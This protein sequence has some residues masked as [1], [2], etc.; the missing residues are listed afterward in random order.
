MPPRTVAHDGPVYQRPFH[1]PAWQDELQADGAEKLP[2]PADRAS[3]ARRCCG[4]SAARTSATGRGSPTSTTATCSATPCSRSRRTPAWCAST[5]RP[6]SGVALATDCN[7]RFAKLDPYAGARLALAESYRNV[8]VSGAQPLAVSDCLNFGS[9]EDPEVMWQFAEAVRGLAD[10]CQELGIPVTGGNVS[11]Y[12]QTGTTAILPTPVVA[13]LGV[14]DDVTRRTPAGFAEADATVLLLGETREELSGSEWA[15]VVHGHLGGLPPVVDLD[16]E[17]RLAEVLVGAGAAG[18]LRLG[19]RPLRRRAGPGAGRVRD[20]P[21]RGRL[22]GGRRR[23]VRRAVLRVGRSGAGVR[24]RRGRRGRSRRAADELGVP[25]AEVGR[26]GGT[27]LTVSSAGEELFT[28]PV[29][30]LRA[31]WT[32]TLRTALA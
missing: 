10:G 28:L 15:N 16:A 1:R 25:V 5:R 2:R 8:A 20:A 30:S 3:W 21:R 23:P 31:S 14:I 29:E 12:N 32:P 6:D 9:P 4:C 18:E 13:V 24:A 11:L 22:G 19:P 27:S 26:T 7:G 17:R